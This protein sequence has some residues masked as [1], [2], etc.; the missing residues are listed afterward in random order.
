MK[1]KLDFCIGL[2]TLSLAFLIPLMPYLFHPW[3]EPLGVDVK[4]YGVHERNMDDYLWFTDSILKGMSDMVGLELSLKIF[5]VMLSI[6]T[7]FGTYMFMMGLNYSSKWCWL[8]SLFSTMSIQVVAGLYAYVVAEWWAYALLL[9]LSGLIVQ[10]DKFKLGWNWF[11]RFIIAV[12]FGMIF[13]VHRF[14]FFVMAGL[15][16]VYL[17]L[18]L[19]KTIYGI[20]SI[21][22]LTGLIW[23]TELDAPYRDNVLFSDMALDVK[24]ISWFQHVIA[25]AHNS[26]LVY[27]GL[28]GAIGVV[29]YTLIVR[30]D[31][32]KWCWMVILSSLL[33]PI[34]FSADDFAWRIT[35]LFP[36]PVFAT[37]LMK[38]LYDRKQDWTMTLIIITIAV[39]FM[40]ASTWWHNFYIH[41]M[42]YGSV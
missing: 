21:V 31:F 30:S 34:F 33:L 18:R 12:F 16:A 10:H 19:K 28:L 5:P 7:F 36:Y 29:G 8:A 15:F 38:W 42:L 41:F 22:T 23:I 24:I 27:L 9:P 25:G 4:F 11:D 6:F 14:A 1:F 3:L 37:I 39:Q 40:I 20:I 17:I 26:P 13:L 2:L 35:Y 32:N